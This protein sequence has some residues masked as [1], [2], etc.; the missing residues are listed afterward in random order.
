MPGDTGDEVR[1]STGAKMIR[2]L[3]TV[4]NR[5]Q[6]RLRWHLYDVAF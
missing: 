1:S 2:F 6:K 3:T 5:R 4:N